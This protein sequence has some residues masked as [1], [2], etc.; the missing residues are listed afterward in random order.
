VDPEKDPEEYGDY[1]GFVAIL[2]RSGFVPVL[3]NGKHTKKEARK[4]VQKIKKCSDGKA[5]LYLSDALVSYEDI[6]TEAYSE[7]HEYPKTGKRG[8]PRKPK[9]IIDPDLLYAQIVKKQ[10]N[11]KL[12]TIEKRVVVGTEKKV[13]QRIQ[14]DGRGSTINTSFVENRNGGYRRENKRL[15]RKTQCHSKKRKF[16]DAQT[17]LSTAFHNFIKPNQSLRKKINDTNKKFVKK[18]DQ[19][20]PAMMEG[21]TDHIWSLE[22]L[23]GMRIPKNSVIVD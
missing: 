7:S 15:C 16:H 4:F 12:E 2:P 3:H 23:L 14:Q 9:R 13:L 19:K 5:P 21:L 6:I 8:R 20:T 11:G 1:W 17:T 18:Y 22:K 10:K